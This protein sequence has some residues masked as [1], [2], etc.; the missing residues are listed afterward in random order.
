[1]PQLPRI[2]FDAGLRVRLVFTRSLAG[3]GFSE[4]AF[5]LP[6]AVLIGI[7]SAGAAVAFHELIHQ[8]RNLLYEHAFSPEFLY[9]RGVAMLVFLPALYAIWFK[10]KQNAALP[11]DKAVP[12]HGLPGKSAYETRR[13]EPLRRSTAT[14]S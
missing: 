2:L 10:I 5:L 12:L 7:V 8:I 11:S 9:G 1:M 4:Y 6:L 13:A 14:A 3:L